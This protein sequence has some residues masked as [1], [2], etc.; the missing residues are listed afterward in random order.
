MS[1][2]LPRIS[3]VQVILGITAVA[4]VYFVVTAGV[5]FIQS[6]QLGHQEAQLQAEIE[7]IQERYERLEAL[8]DYLNSDEYIEAVAREQLGL[9]RPGET[10]FIA[11]SSVPTP[12][13]A[14]DGQRPALWWEMLIR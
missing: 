1:K 2:H 6:R 3:T 9:V 8:R 13:P 11:I 4:I 5:N 14:P 12:T 10:G 7:S